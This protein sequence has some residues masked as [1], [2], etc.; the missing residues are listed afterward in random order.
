MSLEK[1]LFQGVQFREVQVESIGTEVAEGG[2]G[3]QRTA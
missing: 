1:S 3:T 2:R